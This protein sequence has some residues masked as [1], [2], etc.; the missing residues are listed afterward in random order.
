MRKGPETKEYACWKHIRSRCNNPN[1]A[2]YHRYGARGQN[3]KQW[4]EE[5]GMIY[6]TVRIRMKRLGWS[7]E[8][9]F[10]TPI[11][12]TRIPDSLIQF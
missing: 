6:E 9:A 12:N 4:A 5:F 8:R 7:P 1:N 10:T 11:Q 3:V 2:D